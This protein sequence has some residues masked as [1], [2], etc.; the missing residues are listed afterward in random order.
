MIIDYILSRYEK[1]TYNSQ[2]FH[3]YLENR[4]VV[5][6]P[7]EVLSAI[8]SKNEAEVKASLCRYLIDNEYNPRIIDYVLSVD[9]LADNKEPVKSNIDLNNK[10]VDEQ[11]Y[12]KQIEHYKQV[13]NTLSNKTIYNINN[14]IENDDFEREEL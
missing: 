9:W 13:V 11:E 10:P 1:G 6:N 3:N 8:D 2:S 14:Q 7:D 5:G 12:Q 4:C